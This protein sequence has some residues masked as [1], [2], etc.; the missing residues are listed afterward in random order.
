MGIFVKNMKM[1]KN[2]Y[3]CPFR[4]RNPIGDKELLM[5]RTPKM[6]Y[7]WDDCQKGRH[8]DCPLKDVSAP[9]FT[10]SE[11]VEDI[12]KECG[13][14]EEVTRVFLQMKSD[15]DTLFRNNMAFQYLKENTDKGNR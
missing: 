7:G 10:F 6:Y 4:H 1:P 15:L 2:C 14:M 8:P 5:C 11:I 13:T 12:F 3:E 9:D